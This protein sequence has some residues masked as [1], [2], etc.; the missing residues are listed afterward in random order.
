MSRYKTVLMVAAAAALVALCAAISFYLAAPRMTPANPSAQSAGNPGLL[1]KAG[2]GESD[3][4]LKLGLQNLQGTEHPPDYSAALKCFQ[5]AAL[6]GNAQAQY[7]LG[8]LYQTGRGVQRD[9]TN[10][11]FWFE[12][13]ASQNH[14]E[15][16]YNLGSLRLGPR[17]PA[18]FPKGRAVLSPGRR[19]G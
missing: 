8:T 11:L 13:A 17:R 19:V 9:Y 14:V 3:V 4:Q 5:Q 18:R 2:A 1:E 16:L 7:L 15:A 12:K 6:A 10:A